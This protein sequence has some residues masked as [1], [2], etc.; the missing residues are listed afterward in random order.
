[1]SPPQGSHVFRENTKNIFLSETT[2]FSAT[3]DLVLHCLPMSHK[4]TLGI[5]ELSA[6]RVKTANR[7]G[8]TLIYTRLFE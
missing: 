5:N 2:S 3:S 4:W 6:L 1:M 7:N 8:T